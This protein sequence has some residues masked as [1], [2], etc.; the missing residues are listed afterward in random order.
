MLIAWR[1]GDET[2]KTVELDPSP[3]IH[4][5]IC[6]VTP[7]IRSEPGGLRRILLREIPAEAVRM[8][9]SRPGGLRGEFI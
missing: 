7:R 1:T 8:A 4:R 3:R 6:Q 2:V 5:R 9:A